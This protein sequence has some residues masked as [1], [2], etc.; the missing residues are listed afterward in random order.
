[1]IKCY[2]VNSRKTPKNSPANK[3]RWRNQF[4]K[5][6]SNW[7]E[8]GPRNKDKSPHPLLWQCDS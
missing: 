3:R 7:I 8:P 6:K 5:H 4:A 1:M 2:L